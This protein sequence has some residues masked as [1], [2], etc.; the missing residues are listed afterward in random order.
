MVSTL[1]CLV[2]QWEGTSFPWNGA[3]PGPRHPHEVPWIWPSPYF[4]LHFL[5]FTL[6]TEGLSFSSCSCRRSV[7]LGQMWLGAVG[8]ILVSG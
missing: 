6:Y 2:G 4:S 1:S 8:L 7:F 3:S 5:T